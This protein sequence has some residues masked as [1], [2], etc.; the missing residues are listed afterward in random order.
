M[1]KNSLIALLMRVQGNPE[2]YLS[3]DEEGNSYHDII[4]PFAELEDEDG[5]SQD[6]VIIFPSHDY[7]EF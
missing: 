7:K 4:Y 3:S 2:I 5:N 1:R 6:I